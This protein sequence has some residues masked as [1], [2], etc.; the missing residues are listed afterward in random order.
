MRQ[1]EENMSKTSRSAEPAAASALAH[2]GHLEDSARPLIEQGTAFMALEGRRIRTLEGGTQPSE[3]VPRERF[4]VVVIGAGQAGLSVGYHLAR[5]GLSFVILDAEERIGDQW[6]RRWDSLRLFTPAKLDGLDGMRF[7]APGDSSP[8]KDEMGDYLEAYAARFNL[9]VRTGMRVDSLARAGGGYVVTAAGRQFEAAQVVVAAASYQKPRIPSSAGDLDPSI[10][11]LH[12]SDYRRPSQLQPGGVLLVGAGNSGS[13]IAREL[14]P[15]H[16]VWMAGRDVGQLPF[17][18]GGFWGRRLLVRLVLRGLFHRVLTVDTPIGRKARAALAHK[19]GPLIR[20]RQQELTALGVERAPRFAGARGGMPLLDDGQVLEVSNVIWCT[21][22]DPGLSWIDLPI[23]DEHG[24]PKHERGM[25][26]GEP[27][28]YF[29]GVH[30][31]YAASSG[32]IHGVGRD[33]RRIAD[34]AVR[35]RNRH[36]A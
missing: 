11:Q 14:A 24:G 34:A 9:P 27:G 20:V 17:R 22:F 6:R 18:I 35:M 23:F 33:A 30:F 36:P 28:L 21:G 7:P 5:R 19:G 26:P 13:E 32:M 1:K 2:A 29:V 8:T 31:L 3:G 15:R 25:V 12:S 10:V 4:D 16:R